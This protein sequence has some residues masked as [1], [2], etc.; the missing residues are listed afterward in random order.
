MVPVNQKGHRG[1]YSNSQ[2]GKYNLKNPEK[3]QGQLPLIYK[4]KLE[5]A[6]MSYLDHNKKI[7]VWSYE[8]MY[9]FYLDKSSNPPVKRKYYIDFTFKD[10]TGK[11]YWV[12]VKHS[13]EVNV[14]LK[15]ADPQAIKIWKKNQSKWNAAKL[16]AESKGCSFN[17]ITEK[18]LR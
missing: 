15:K 6:F 18:Q 16:L 12:E 9:I 5:R 10:I 17:I 8:P 1:K 11:K 14:D 13:S 7:A 2:V 4:S 3:Y